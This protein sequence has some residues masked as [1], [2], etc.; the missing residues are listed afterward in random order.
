MQ[1]NKTET[2]SSGDYEQF[3]SELTALL[4]KYSKENDSDT[5]NHLL[6]YYL[7][8]CLTAYNQAVQARERWHG[9]QVPGGE[10]QLGNS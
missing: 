9:R 3:M 10:S 8:N 6:A 2:S 7:N 5:P 4:N 1:S